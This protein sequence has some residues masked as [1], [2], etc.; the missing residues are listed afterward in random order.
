MTESNLHFDSFIGKCPD[1]HLMAVDFVLQTGHVFHGTTQ[2]IPR[3]VI[4]THQFVKFVL[5]LGRFLHETSGK[6]M[7]KLEMCA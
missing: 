7:K 3:S 1:L 4:I 5:L 2:F 6:I